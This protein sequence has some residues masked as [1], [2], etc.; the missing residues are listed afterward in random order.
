MTCKIQYKRL[1]V[2]EIKGYN[3]KSKRDK[4]QK[5]MR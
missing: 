2:N 3:S 5:F 4:G 1:E